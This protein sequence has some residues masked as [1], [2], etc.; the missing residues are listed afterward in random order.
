MIGSLIASRTELHEN[1]I[2][3]HSRLLIVIRS[4]DFVLRYFRVL[5]TMDSCHHA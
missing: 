2:V 1:M 4:R 3:A 5:C